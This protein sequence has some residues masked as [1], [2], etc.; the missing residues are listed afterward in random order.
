MTITHF[1]C[2]LIA[3]VYGSILLSYMLDVPTARIVACIATCVYV[4]WRDR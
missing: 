2:A 4:I 1:A 3:G